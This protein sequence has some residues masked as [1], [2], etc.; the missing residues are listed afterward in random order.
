[1]QA[2]AALAVLCAGPALAF[3]GPATGA[4]G[5][6]V[7]KG[8]LTAGVAAF[9]SG[10][11]V[12]L[13]PCVYPMIAVTVSV[14]G[15]REARSRWEGAGLSAAFVLGIVAMFVPLGVAVGLSGG[16]FGSILNSTF[17]VVGISVL[18]FAMA[19]S[20]FGA[21]D[22]ALP[23][24]LNNRL[25]Q[26]GGIGMKGA[27]LLGLCCGPIAAPCTGPFLTGILAWIGRTGSAPLGALAMTAFSLGLGLPFFVVGTFAV[28]LPKSGRWMVHVK[29]L[30]GVILIAVGLYFLAPKLPILTR[31]ASPGWKFTAGAGAAV[32][33]GLLLGAIHRSFEEPGAGIKIRKALGVLLASGGAFLM[34]AGY[35]VPERTLSWERSGALEAR[36][37]AQREGRPFL[38]DFTAAWCTAC[39]E[40]D[41]ATF[42]EPRVA[43]EAGRF[44]AVKVDAT[45]QD[46]PKVESA[47]KEFGV[48]GL[49]TVV[50]FDSAGK[51]AARYTEF[52]EAPRFLAALERTQ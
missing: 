42:A 32:V 44:V 34:V 40:L 22:L 48:I 18:L 52:V 9:V 12:G 47:M 26:V 3:A 46:D 30:M 38:V 43:S 20:M 33:A 41:K 49:P 17:V 11:L 39:H 37:R 1:M 5:E 50:V 31:F 21:F 35:L 25:A 10:V 6:A 15:A 2:L 27:F 24:S 36:S 14:F 7:A 45:D 4:F 28:Q 23:A 19:A 13:T 29:S 51:E 8:P 16:V